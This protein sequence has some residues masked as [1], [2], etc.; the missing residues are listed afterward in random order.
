MPPKEDDYRAS[1]IKDWDRGKCGK[2]IRGRDEWGV[3]RGMSEEVD[4]WPLDPRC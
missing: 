4:R 2:E 1:P 3:E